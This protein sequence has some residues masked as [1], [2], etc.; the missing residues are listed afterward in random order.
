[1]RLLTVV[2]VLQT[3]DVANFRWHFYKSQTMIM[4]YYFKTRKVKWIRGFRS[5]LI[6]AC[7]YQIYFVVW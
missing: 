6:Y 2:F 5:P 3:Y 1:M 4:I 7:T